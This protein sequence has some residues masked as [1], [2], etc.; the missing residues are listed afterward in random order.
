MLWQHSIMLFSF[1]EQ[2]L[3]YCISVFQNENAYDQ[4]FVDSNFKTYI[5]KLRAKME[6]YNVSKD[7]VYRGLTHCFVSVLRKLLQIRTSGPVIQ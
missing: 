1:P 5:F 6:T 7:H 2:Y 3:K 4:V